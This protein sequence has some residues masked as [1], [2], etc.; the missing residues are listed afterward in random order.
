MTLAC[1]VIWLATPQLI[2]L[3]VLAGWLRGSPRCELSVTRSNVVAY[4]VSR[5]VRVA[6][7]FLFGR[8]TVSMRRIEE[9]ASQGALAERRA[10]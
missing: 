6:P 10:L 1:A 7:R 2:E 4:E 5:V 9:S 8:G 3:G